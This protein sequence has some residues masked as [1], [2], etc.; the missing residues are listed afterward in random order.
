MEQKRGYS[1]NL[2][3]DDFKELTLQNCTY[4]GS[5]PLYRINTHTTDNH[6]DYIYNGVDRVDNARGYEVDN[7]VTCCKLCNQMKMNLQLE[8]F[9]RHINKINNKIN[10][11]DNE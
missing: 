8:E 2:S 1:F 4:C 6:G 11:E 10:G 9:K 7:C 3:K 5:E